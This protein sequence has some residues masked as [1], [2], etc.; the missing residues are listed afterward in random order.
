MTVFD[1]L[2]G[3][4]AAAAQLGAAAAAAQEWL[5]G[6]RGTGMTHAWLF[7]G[8][9][10]SGRTEAALAFA[11][12]LQC[13]HGGCGTCSSCHQIG[14]G[15][16]ADVLRVRPSGLSMGVAQTRDLVRSSAAAPVGGRFRVVVFED[17]D[18][19]TEAA[20]NALLKAVEEPPA[21]TVWLL[22]T[23]TSDDLPVTIRSRC[24]AVVLRTPSTRAVATVLHQRNGVPWDEAESVAR[25]AGGHLERAV[26]LATDEKAWK[27]REAVLSLP[28]QLDGLGSAIAAAA[29]L[30]Q[31]AEAEAKQA[32]EE[33]DERERAELKAAFGDGAT[34][35]G[36]TKAVRAASGALKDL[37]A[38]QKRRATR[39][40][41]DVY[42]GA[43]LDLVAFYRDVLALQVGAQVDRP[44]GGHDAELRHVART[45]GPRDTLA[46]IEAVQECRRRID[47]NVN[48]QI[49]LEAMTARLCTG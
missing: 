47:A 19:A 15:T 8:P 40:K 49:A 14:A 1:E 10:G 48:P 24:R 22:C 37:E 28:A 9:P 42:D 26:R 18:R 38:R 43:L 5:D 21:R 29:H 41:R 23:P 6:G 2:V 17:A 25:A 20:A 33:R 13:P 16:H 44:T 46:R 39:I 3:Q 31:T 35:K 45:S 4:D 11:A 27:N 34:G 30:H 12:A 32:T 7:T 36:V